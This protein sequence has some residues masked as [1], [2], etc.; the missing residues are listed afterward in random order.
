MNGERIVTNTAD[1]RVLPEG[2]Q[3]YLDADPLDEFGFSGW[4]GPEP[5]GAD[6]ADSG[7]IRDPIYADRA[8]QWIDDRVAARRGGEPR[9]PAVPA[10]LL[11][12]QPP[13][14]RA[15]AAVGEDEPAHPVVGAAPPIP[16]SPTD[17]EDLSTKPSLQIAYR[18]A[19]FSG[20]GPSAP[21][22]RL[23]E[24][25]AERYRGT[26]YRLHHDVDGPIDRVRRAVTDGLDDA[27]MVLTSDHG[28]LL[29]SHGGLHQKWYQLYDEATRVPFVLAGV[30]SRSGPPGVVDA[31]TSHVDLLPTLLGV[32][33]VDE[34][35]VATELRRTHSEVHPLPGRDLAPA[36]D[37]ES[38]DPREPIYLIT[39]DNMLEGDGNA[40]ALLAARGRPE[41]PFPLQIRL[42]AHAPTNVEA[43]VTAVDGDDGTH[44]WKLARTFD[45][46][47]TWT[48]PHVRQISARGPAGPV[49]RT[50]PIPDQWEL[51][52]LSDDPAE[53]VNRWHDPHAAVV[54][55]Q[56]ETLLD[57]VR[58]TR[59]PERNAAWETTPRPADTPRATSPPPPARVLRRVLQRIG[60]HPDDPEAVALDLR[61][62]RA[63]IVGT[64]HGTLDVGKPTGVFGSELTAPYYEF[65][66][67]GMT[68]DIASP[69]GGDI[70]FDPASFRPVI[71]SVHDDRF[72]ADADALE[73]V[74]HSH[75]IADLDMRDYDIV[76]FA[77]GWGAAWDLGTSEAVG[78]QASA[79]A[80]HGAVLGG[81]CH[82]PLG[83][84]QAQDPRRRPS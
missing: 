42:P 63:L 76:F 45:D 2:V 37:G 77:G 47:S 5:H 35:E 43:V 41:A 40:A 13:R 39:R 50:E 18:D 66:D 31:P 7:T 75:A 67:A 84:L 82:G 27:V 8:V 23:Y 59:V 22:R 25:Q 71:R 55:A 78:A 10:D 83:L 11:V 53:S 38:V 74:K 36:L 1:G 64:N 34:Q 54:R 65:L 9:G 81:G 79:A 28:D 32:A 16:P 30:G 69:R 24:R 70:P 46:P 80:A 20:Y 60:L 52:D 21:V 57:D 29:G 72:L 3:A 19:Y 33:G 51:Y 62:R 73:K 6:W 17:D 58:A 12:R 68:V 61:G 4:I 26:Y 48:D 44:L 14:H 49:Y 56:L 15:V